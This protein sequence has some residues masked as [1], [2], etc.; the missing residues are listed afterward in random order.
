[1]QRTKDEKYKYPCVYTVNSKSNITYYYSSEK[2]GHY[3]VSKLIWSNGRISS[4]GSYID[5]NGDYGLTQF[6]YA[7]IDKPENLH[8]IKE[9]FDSKEF[10]KLMEL[11]AV[12]QL[13]VNYKI[14]SIFKKEFWKIFAKENEDIEQKIIKPKKKLILIGETIDKN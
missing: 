1:M 4:I 9:A 5:I 10:R 11:C 6:A 7:I 14:I 12:G 3:G 2:K 8:K 13:T